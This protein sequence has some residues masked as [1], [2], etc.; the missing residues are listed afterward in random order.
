VTAFTRAK[1]RCDS[2]AHLPRWRIVHPAPI[3]CP[4]CGGTRLSKIGEDVSQTLDVVPRPLFITQHVGQKFSCRSC[5]K[6]TQPLA[7]FQSIA[8]GFA[9]PS[10]LA[11]ILVDKYANH[12]PLNW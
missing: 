9:G 12:Q 3:A 2:L 1:T 10:L 11:M 4:C 5:D 8:R 7:S 6:I